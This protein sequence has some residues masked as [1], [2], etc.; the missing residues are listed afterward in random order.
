MVCLMVLL[1]AI[2][3]AQTADTPARF[4]PRIGFGFT[5]TLT[6][7]SEKPVALGLHA[8]MSYPVTADFSI[9]AGVGLTGFILQ[10]RDDA[11]YYLTPKA[12]GI[13]TLDA[14][15]I[16]SPYV[17]FGL[18]GYLPI[19]ENTEKGA[20]GPTLY[21]GIGW[22]LSLSAQTSVYFEI[23]PALVIGSETTSL[24]LPLNVGVV[25]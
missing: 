8:R 3:Q 5:P 7:D 24:I 25:L 20:G 19:G 18:G 23:L 2:A 17:L 21:G 9:G 4:S 12:L 13:V 6:I 1:A 11:E 16:R 22:A 10:G 15:N 14:T